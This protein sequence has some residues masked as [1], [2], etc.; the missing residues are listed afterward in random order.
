MRLGYK[1]TSLAIAGSFLLAGCAN[2]QFS[3]SKIAKGTHSS[4][5]LP[6]PGEAASGGGSFLDE[7]LPESVLSINLFDQD[8][9][10]FTLG[11]FENK[12]I[13][14]GNFLTSCQEIC[15]M[16]TANMRTIGETIAN[17][18]L[19]DSIK[20][21]EIS[22][23]AERDTST[24]LKSYR[25]LYQ[26]KAFTLASGTAADLN[27]I[28]NY[29]GAP[30]KKMKYTP[31][32]ESKL[33]V[34]WLTGKP[35]AYDVMHPNLVLIIGPDQKWKWL[36]LGNPNPG[37]ATIPPKL[38]AFLSQDGLKNLAKPEEPSWSVKAVFSALSDL[39]GERIG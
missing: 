5:T 22:V 30:A 11:D 12:F 39:T 29:F 34:D 28:W 20:V 26:S 25:D 38:K 10:K 3:N 15:P 19:K 2:N 9:H 36:D 31:S 27:K 21:I 7:A 16:T 33:P 23:D 1:L 32:E 37:S 14:I 8:G 6:Q 24:R 18:K 35:P 4:S 13:V 17:S